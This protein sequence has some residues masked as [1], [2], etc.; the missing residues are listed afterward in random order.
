MKKKSTALV[1]VVSPAA[2]ALTLPAGY[3]R[4]LT[5]IKQR[6]RA[7]QVRASLAASRELVQLY[8]DVGGMIVQRQQREG[9]G[10]SVIERLARDIQKAFPALKGFSRQNIWFMRA[11]HLA[12]TRDLQRLQQPARETPRKKLLQPARETGMAAMVPQAVGPLPPQFSA[13]WAGK[14]PP[15]AV[16]SIPWFHNVVLVHRVK[17]PVERLWY[18]QAALEHG[19]S[20]D[21]LALQIESR[22]FHRKGKAVTNFSRTLPAPQ[23]DLAAQMLKDPYVFD[24][25]TL[26]DAARERDI[27]R[28]LVQHLARF[29]VE[30]GAGFAYVGRQVHLVVGT[31]DS[32]LDLLFYHTRLHCYVVID[33]K[34]RGFTPEDAGKMNFY[35]SAVDAQMRQPEDKPSIG[36]L[37]CRN[38]DRLVAEYALRDIHKP[39][40]VAEWKTKLTRALPDNL[41]SSLPS[42]EEIEAELAQDLAPLRQ[43]KPRTGQPA[44]G[45]KNRRPRGSTRRKTPTAPP[46]RRAKRKTGGRR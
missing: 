1:P 36:L 3:A 29:L 2:T 16:L 42:I 46:P 18:A 11:F 41:K 45:G 24:F 10:A 26:T 12:W 28:Q 14:L 43:S 7:A 37:L 13:D 32:Y 20:R 40:G 34:D 35:L 17:D 44:A 5:D 19:W 31:T 4:V 30:L 22:L 38:R 9:W 8:W 21:I 6:I 27:E 15:P 25:L 33:L 23:S 39:I